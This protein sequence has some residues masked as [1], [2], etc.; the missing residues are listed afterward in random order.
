MIKFGAIKDRVYKPLINYNGMSR[1]TNGNRVLI[2]GGTSGTN[3][4]MYSGRGVLFN[5]TDQSIDFNVVKGQT[6]YKF[7]HDLKQI[8]IENIDFNGVYSLGKVN[9]TGDYEAVTYGNI[10]VTNVPFTP[11]QVKTQ[12]N[13]PE[14]FL[15]HEKQQDGTFIPKSNFLSQEELNSV[16]AH[17]PMCETDGFVRNMIGYS[18]GAN[19]VDTGGTFLSDDD[20][21]A[22]HD[23]ADGVHTVEV[24]TAGTNTVRPYI[25]INISDTLEVGSTYLYS[26]DIKVISGTFGNYAF[27]LN[28]GAKSTKQYSGS[29]LSVYDVAIAGYAQSELAFIFDGT[30]TFKIEISNIKVQELTETYAI[31]NFTDATRSNAKNLSSGLQ[32]CLLETDELGVTIG[33]SF[34]GIRNDMKIEPNAFLHPQ[35]ELGVGYHLIEGIFEYYEDNTYVKMA[36]TYNGF[37]ITK[38]LDNHLRMYLTR[39]GDKYFLVPD[40]AAKSKLVKNTKY[41][42]TVEVVDNGSSVTAQFSLNG[43][44]CT[45]LSKDYT[46]YDVEA[47]YGLLGSSTIKAPA[48]LSLFNIHKTPQDPTKLYADAVKKGLLS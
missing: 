39:D 27:H 1:V 22:T 16:V 21:V 26:F 2:D 40:T 8:V 46:D 11:D 38:Y 10:I 33:N 32:T 43:E 12:Y 23:Y 41:H 19:I 35:Y 14:Q 34:D 9:G 20:E 4:T 24:T 5:G 25:K 13:N 6:L 42:F 29:D 44:L 31:E 37:G 28:N 48:K 47:I 3:A 36:I 17:F 45:S 30:N 7:N 18:E 15:Y